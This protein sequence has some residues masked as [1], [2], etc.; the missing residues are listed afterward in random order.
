LA[1]MKGF[2]IALGTD[3]NDF[4][5]SSVTLIQL[6]RYMLNDNQIMTEA[7]SESKF[8]S[9]SLMLVMF[10]FLMQFINFNMIRALISHS[11]FTVARNNIVKMSI[12]ELLQVKHW[13]VQLQEYKDPLIN[14][15]SD[16]VSKNK[17]K[18]DSKLATA[19]KLLHKHAISKL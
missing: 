15:L 8:W 14:R 9:S 1:F 16:W 7:V 10:V 4:R 18:K 6:W 11:Y 17:D 2:Q 13:L 3:F 19:A 12:D 5:T